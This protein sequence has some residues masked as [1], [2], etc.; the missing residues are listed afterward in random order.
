M[1]K[2]LIPVLLTAT[3]LAAGCNFPYR[4][5]VAQ[6]NIVTQ[7]MVA[8][9]EPG[10]SKQQVTYVMGT[11]LLVDVFRPDEWVYHYSLR[12]GSGEHEQ[13]RIILVFEGDRLARVTGDVQSAPRDESAPLVGSEAVSVPI[14]QAEEGPGFW[15]RVKRSVGLGD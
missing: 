7:D 10:M 5:D 15:E 3:C 1:R 6:G 9:L 8:R 11:P 4:I 13:R 14:E 2:V 12:H